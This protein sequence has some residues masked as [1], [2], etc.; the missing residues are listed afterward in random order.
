[1][2]DIDSNFHDT[3][4]G[5]QQFGASAVRSSWAMIGQRDDGMEANRELPKALSD[6]HLGLYELLKLGT[7]E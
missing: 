4:A 5:V 1:M 3:L 6:V 2:A 7:T